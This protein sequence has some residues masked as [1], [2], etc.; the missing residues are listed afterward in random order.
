MKLY[1]E[2]KRDFQRESKDFGA[3]EGAVKSLVTTTGL[4]MFEVDSKTFCWFED[5]V[6][7]SEKDKVLFKENKKILESGN[8]VNVVHWRASSKDYDDIYFV[9][10]A[11][12][13]PFPD[14]ML[15]TVKLTEGRE[16]ELKI[17]DR[18]VIMKLLGYIKEETGTHTFDICTIRSCIVCS[19]YTNLCCNNCNQLLCDDCYLV[20]V[21]L[22]EVV[23]DPYT[24]H[25]GDLIE[26]K[27]YP[28]QK[29]YVEVS[30]TSCHLYKNVDDMKN[31]RGKVGSPTT[32][33]GIIKK[34]THYEN[35]DEIVQSI[36]ILNIQ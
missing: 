21:C 3:T 16:T 24:I 30:G 13:I 36:S 31:K 26:H 12:L 15:I 1:R 10:H 25:S 32:R 11:S 29:F 23:S 28:N 7:V 22:E 20:H 17:A 35:E 2:W 5:T 19:L 33:K 14:I 18:R 8:I 9:K 6:Y 27:K 34:F 4:V